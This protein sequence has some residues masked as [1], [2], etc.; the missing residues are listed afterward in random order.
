[1]LLLVQTNLFAQAEEQFAQANELYANGE[2][3]DAARMYE[4]IIQND[5]CS[6]ALYYNLGNAYY[7]TN[8]IGKSILNY[9]RAL[10]LKPFY[11]DAR[12]NLELAQNKVVDK[13]EPAQMF[14]LHHWISMLMNLLPSRTWIWLSIFLF[15]A[16]SASFFMFAFGKKIR[17]RQ[18]GYYIAVFLMILSF[19]GFGFA[20]AMHKKYQQ[21]SEAIIMT[22]TVTIKSSP[23]QSGTDLYV[24]HEGTKV[25]IKSTMK[26]WSEV[27]FGNGNVGWI[28]TRHMERI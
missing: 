10:R 9:E 5:G 1:M 6:A 22:G 13:I 14:F 2:Y 16:S 7:K 21:Q 26:E 8:E 27:S 19:V 15:T 12:H 24:L 17:I 25:N 28:R 23:D 4:D 20:N 18:F 11:K 3:A